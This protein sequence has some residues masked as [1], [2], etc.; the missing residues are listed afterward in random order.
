MSR[1]SNSEGR[2]LLLFTG[3]NFYIPAGVKTLIKVADKY[4]E[5]R[6]ARNTFILLCS[7]PL[8]CFIVHINN[9]FNT[10]T[11]INTDNI[12]IQPNSLD[13]VAIKRFQLNLLN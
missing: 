11:N 4:I 1:R 3:A 7:P 5:L 12:N 6:C 10:G 13:L 9:N 8:L 2:R